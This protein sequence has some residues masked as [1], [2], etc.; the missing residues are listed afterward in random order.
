V[1]T[2]TIDGQTIEVPEET[3]IL[4]AATRLGIDIPTLCHH[5]ALEPYAT[6]RV[7]TVETKQRGRTRMVTACNY[8]IRGDL[9]VF[10]RSERTLKN[11]RMN[12]EL[13]L[14]RCPGVPVLQKLAAQYDVEKPRFALGEE[15]CI[16]CGLCVRVCSDVIGAHALCFAN[17]G[18]DRTVT[19]PWELDTEACL[20]CGACAYVCPTG[21]ITM[22]DLD[23][24]TVVHQELRLGPPKAIS[25]PTLQAVPNVAVI[26]PETCLYFK[27][28]GCK[29]CETMCE[30][31]AINHDM[32]DRHEEFEVG[33]II[34]ATGF[35]Q[36]DPSLIRRYGY[37]RFDNVLTGLEFER[38]CNASGPTRG[39]VLLADGAA[40][41]SIAILHCV[42]SR[43][44]NYSE[45]CSRVCC[46]YSLKFAHLVREKT[47]ARVYQLYIDMRASGKGY[48]EF[49]K[50]VMKEDAIMIRGKAAEVTDEPES[51]EEEGRLIVTCEDTLLGRVRRLPVDMVILSAG[52][53]PRSDAPQVS[54]K[55]T[56]SLSRDGFFMEKHPKLAPVATAFGGLF[57][58]GACQG[59]K[60]IPD[61]VAQGLAAAGE[62]LSLIDKGMVDIEPVT[63]VIAEETCGGCKTC[64]TMCP[65]SAIE[66][67]DEKSISR[68]VEALC[69]GCGTCVAACPS[70]AAT[71]QGFTDEQIFAEIEGNLAAMPA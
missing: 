27:T 41:G 21:C 34:L 45:Y 35:Q 15:G 69:K 32:E 19:T 59:P 56:V 28:G 54:T 1:P 60:D 36:F 49:Y 33:T 3:T 40:P 68:V 55:F 31:E 24:R 18:V 64:L 9:E 26:D 65:Y 53:K 22:E 61:T 5:P 10:T 14:A 57:I 30:R 39:K 43:D 71:Q 44:E 66:F 29:I 52:L 58:A 62:V 51:P 17:R 11:R 38:L 25:V 48:E 63:S 50:R 23:Q 13:L 12:L 20:G 4:Q 70:G 16:L 46:M 42:G 47:D 6:C 2:A 37:G 67:D 7:C 8:P